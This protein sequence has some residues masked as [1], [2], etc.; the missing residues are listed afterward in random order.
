MLLFDLNTS[1]IYIYLSIYLSISLFLSLS[2][3]V[4]LRNF[5]LVNFNFLVSEVVFVRRSGVPAPLHLDQD[6]TTQVKMVKT[7]NYKVLNG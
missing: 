1:L 4:R 5:I 2:T 7:M 3:K 6:W